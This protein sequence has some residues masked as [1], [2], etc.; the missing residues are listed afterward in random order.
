MSPSSIF[1]VFRLIAVFILMLPVLRSVEFLPMTGD[2]V[3]QKEDG[4]DQ[5]LLKYSGDNADFSGSVRWR[6]KGGIKGRRYENWKMESYFRLSIYW[7]DDCESIVFHPLVAGLKM[8]QST[9][10]L[11]GAARTCRV[12]GLQSKEGLVFALVQN[13]EGDYRPLEGKVTMALWNTFSIDNN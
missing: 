5:V 7:M 2:S 11:P 1:L 3:M 13:T 12:I 10:L 9:V 4:Q 6:I 8:T